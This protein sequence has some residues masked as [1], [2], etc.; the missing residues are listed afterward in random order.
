MSSFGVPQG[1]E[2]VAG[3]A[4][5]HHLVVVE[6][7]PARTEGPGPGLADVVEQG[8]QAQQPVGARLVDHGQGVGQH[9]LVAVDGVLL[10]GEARAARAGTRAARPVST[11]NH[12]PGEGL[13][14]TTSLSSSSRMRSAETIASRSCMARTASVSSGSGLRPN[15][16]M[17]RA[18]RSMRSGS[19]EKEISGSSGVRSRPRGEVGEPAVGVD[20]L[21]VGQSQRHGVDG[22]VAPRQVD[23]DGVPKT[24]SGLRESGV[25]GLGPVGGDLVVPAVLA[26]PD[27]PE[28]LAL[29]PHG[30]GP[31]A[32]RGV[33]SRRAARRW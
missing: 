25:V 5:A 7:D 15:P 4:G 32:A 11:M 20:E 12:S 10:E 27:R 6:G 21:E 1:R 17:N 2:A 26:R 28:A 16:A 14:T 24:T 22:E 23:L 33:R 9:V 29:E 3:H 18:A 31:T 8:G 30:V 19:S 13:S